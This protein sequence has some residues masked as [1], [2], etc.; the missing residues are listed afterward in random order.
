MQTEDFNAAPQS[1]LF[2]YYNVL[3]DPGC[4]L[5]STEITTTVMAAVMKEAE[6]GDI[7]ATSS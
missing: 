6:V 3:I 2:G 5:T 4:M 7:T 1:V